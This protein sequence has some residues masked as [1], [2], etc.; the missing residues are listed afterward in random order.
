MDLKWRTTT[1][2]AE[3]LNLY[4][5]TFLLKTSNTITRPCL[6]HRRKKPENILLARIEGRQFVLWLPLISL[7]KGKKQRQLFSRL[8]SIF[9]FFQFS[10]ISKNRYS[11]S[12]PDSF[13]LISS[14]LLCPSALNE[15]SNTCE[16]LTLTGRVL[17]GLLRDSSLSLKGI[18]R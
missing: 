13:P 9:L 16:R 7:F 6:P 14:L 15:S 10:W 17:E 3:K 18:L 12:R 2:M 4:R 8:Y 1:E 5:W 11:Y